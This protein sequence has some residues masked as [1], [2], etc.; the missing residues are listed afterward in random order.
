MN[1]EVCDHENLEQSK[2]PNFCVNQILTIRPITPKAVT[3]LFSVLD[4]LC[5]NNY[6][7][8]KIQY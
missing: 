4:K 7:P 8:Q 3:Q 6:I 1:L 5:K 2:H